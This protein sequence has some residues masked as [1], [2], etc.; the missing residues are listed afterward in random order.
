MLPVNERLRDAA[1][2][3]AHDLQHYANGVIRRIIATLNRSD[4]AIF[5]Q[6]ADALERMP[7]SAFSVDRLEQL[8][9]GVR[10]LN[11]RAYQAIENELTP[12]MRALT[13]YEANYQNQLIRTTLPQQVIARVGVYTVNVEQV[14]A[15]ALARP[16]QGVLLRQ[17]L[18]GLEAN[19]AK[20]IRQTLA[21]GYVESRT[22]SE[23]V[24]ELRGT[25]ARGYADGLFDKSRRETEAVVRT[26]T[27]H[28]AAFTRD[29]FVAANKDLIKAVQWVSTLDTHT[30]QICILRDGKRYT[31]ETHQP[32]GHSLPWLG[33]AGNAHWNCR[34][35]AVPITL[36]FRELG[37]NIDELPPGTRASM[38]GQVPADQN[39]GEWL[40]KQSAARQ[41]EILGPTRGKLMR[42]GGLTVDRFANDKG[43]WLTL[44]QLRERDAAAFGKAGL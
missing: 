6:L 20:L 5:A 25:R 43:K 14:Y 16:F 17:A 44:D 10:E 19:R 15:A 36:S 12:E 40:Q 2:S 42:D 26:A 9:A 11:L 38:D 3:H 33:G 37:I 34:S 7:A 21:R 30:T 18:T 24:R 1:V 27:S 22:I 28:F 4:A 13:A 32:I 41:D 8:L 39:Y 31:T 35:T 23:M 29:R